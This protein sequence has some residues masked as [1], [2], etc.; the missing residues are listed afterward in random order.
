MA[1]QS[2]GR[3]RPSGA[4]RNRTDSSSS[5]KVP[6]RP[7]LHGPGPVS[8]TRSLR[9]LPL[10]RGLGGKAAPNLRFPLPGPRATPSTE[11]HPLPRS[12]EALQLDPLAPQRRRPEIPS[13]GGSPSSR[14]RAEAPADQDPEPALAR[15]ARW[16]RAGHLLRRALAH[17]LPSGASPAREPQG[18][19]A[20]KKES[21]WGGG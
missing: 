5:T 18:I 10:G 6:S 1:A 13:G 16:R 21:R 17:R 14:G 3:E 9:R 12:R 11:T 2:G 15:L 20:G 8:G 7:S 19:G 4:P